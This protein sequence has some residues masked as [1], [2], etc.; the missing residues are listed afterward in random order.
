MNY[1][2]IIIRK[3]PNP[4]AAIEEAKYRESNRHRFENEMPEFRMKTV[5]SLICELTD[6]QYKKVKAAC[7]DVFQ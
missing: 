1:K 5:D 2:L 6:E 4:E 7:L 3:E